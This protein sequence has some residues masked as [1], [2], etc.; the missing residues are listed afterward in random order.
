MRRSQYGTS[1]TCSRG[2]CFVSHGKLQAMPHLPLHGIP[3]KA[4]HLARLHSACLPVI[5]SK[6]VILP[7]LLLWAGEHGGS[8]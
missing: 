2:Q 8:W 7:S 3:V 5:I 6:G 1:F 4:L